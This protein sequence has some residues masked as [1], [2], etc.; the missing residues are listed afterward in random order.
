MVAKEMFEKLGYDFKKGWLYDKY[1]DALNYHKEIPEEDYNEE[2]ILFDVE[3]RNY[4]K[5]DDYGD[6]IPITMEELQAINQQC[7]E[8]GW[9]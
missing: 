9:I 8:L 5:E 7:K 1:V 2:Y 3:E 4:W 6:A